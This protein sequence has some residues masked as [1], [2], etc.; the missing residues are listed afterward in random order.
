MD[1]L[2]IIFAVLLSL[3]GIIGCIIPGLPGHPL[4]Y[5][6]ML[7]LHWAFQP[8][9]ISTLLIFGILTIAI[10]VLDYMI[11]LWTGKKFGATKQGI[12]GSIIGMLLGMAFTPIGMILGTLLGAVIGDMIAGR[13]T[14]QATKSGLGTLFGTFLSIGIKLIL[15]GTMSFFVV[16]EI[17]KFIL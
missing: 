11:P 16:Y 6:A 7:L 9:A 4:N 1:T 8:F 3:T 2:L 14:A 15:S 17:A 5:I 10:T 12:I 13:T